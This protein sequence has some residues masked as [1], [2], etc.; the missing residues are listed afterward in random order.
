[1]G[2]TVSLKALARLA[3][4]RDSARDKGRDSAQDRPV[5]LFPTHEMRAYGT[6]AGQR[7]PWVCW[8]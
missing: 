6:V 1:M 5:P 3:I 8:L 7:K 4:E 2:E